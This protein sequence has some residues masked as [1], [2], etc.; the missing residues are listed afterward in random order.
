MPRIASP[1][2]ARGERGAPPPPAA[3]RTGRQYEHAPEAA[4]AIRRVLVVCVG[5]VCRSPVAEFVLRQHLSGRDVIVESAGIAA[6]D[7][8]RI[9]P[10][11]L[12][13]LDRHGIDADAHVARRLDRTMLDAADLVLVM[14]R[15]HLEF[16]RSQVPSSAGKTFLLGKW[17]GGFEIPDPFGKPKETFDH[18]YRMVDLAARRWCTMI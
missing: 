11:A 16:I 7:G 15:S 10:R 5:N 1:I 8:A 2:E 4:F 9:E 18:L 14:E 13:V 3:V 6:I 17:Q 12:A